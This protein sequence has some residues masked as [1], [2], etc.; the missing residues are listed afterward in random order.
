[1]LSYRT[2]A[3]RMRRF[4][5]GLAVSAL[6][7]AIVAFT[8]AWQ[9][10]TFASAPVQVTVGPPPADLPIEPVSI[11]SKSG[12]NLAGWLVRGLPRSGAVLLMHGVRA[13]RLEMLARTRL[14][15]K[16][17]FS[18][19][20]F[21]FQAHGESPGQNITF[22][23]LESRD[24]RAAFDYLHSAMPGERIGIVGMSLGGAATILADPPLEADAIVLEA[25]F[26]SFRRAVANRLA[27]RLGGMG[28]LLAPMLVWQVKLRLGFDPQVLA[29]VNRIGR[30]RVPL[31]L[32]AGSADAHATLSEMDKLYANA[33]QPKELWVIAGATHADFQR[34]A[35][36]AYEQHVVGF[37]KARLR[38]LGQR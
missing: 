21:D 29:P 5:C 27:I 22:G 18:V 7:T 15:Y 19:L 6:A 34:Y 30:L 25:V 24:A 38:G 11:A 20:L 23:Y 17:G 16:H 31:L 12:S 37:L 14:L 9:V 35:P 1:V 28:R 8:A 36:A 32:I 26:A 33:N 3:P 13:N 2:K 4:G 10:G